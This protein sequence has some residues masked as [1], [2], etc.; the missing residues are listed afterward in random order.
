MRLIQTTAF[1]IAIDPMTSKSRLVL[2]HGED[3]KEGLHIDVPEYIAREAGPFIGVSRAVTV[4][5]EAG[6]DNAAYLPEIETR[7]RASAEAFGPG[8]YETAWLTRAADSVRRVWEGPPTTPIDEVAALREECDRLR[9][10]VQTLTTDY[11][12]AQARIVELNARHEAVCKLATVRYQRIA[13]LEAATVPIGHI[14]APPLVNG[15][16]SCCE[17]MRD[18]CWNAWD[19]NIGENTVARHAL[20]FCPFCGAKLPEVK[21]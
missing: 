9:S 11:Q 7:L 14:L 19:C 1:G 12:S 6:E 18:A 10:T 3:F 20:T 15:R 17:K 4:T 13:E 8:M 5:I 16:P 21:P 2:M